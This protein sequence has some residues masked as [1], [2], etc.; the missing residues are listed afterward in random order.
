MTVKKAGKII[1]VYEDKNLIVD[2]AKFLLAHLLAGETKGMSITKI[3]FGTNGGTPTPGDTV[4][5]N[6]FLKPLNKIS[7]PG[8]VAEEVN[9]G[10]VLGIKDDLVLPWHGYKVQFDWEL[11]TTEDNGHSISEFGL[12][13]DNN[14]LFARKSRGSPIVKA[15][16]ISIEGSWIIT[17]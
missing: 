7:F 2:N 3:G 10:P 16:D 1:E 6:P 15:P 9:F 5:K 11:M 12:I 13:T 4:L 14:A 17:F 8:Y